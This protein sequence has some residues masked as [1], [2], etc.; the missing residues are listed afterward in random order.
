MG[1]LDL[2]LKEEG[3][4]AGYHTIAPLDSFLVLGEGIK[5]LR[6]TISYSLGMRTFSH[7]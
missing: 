1:R 6:H 2:G 7:Y 4:L 5:D 3:L